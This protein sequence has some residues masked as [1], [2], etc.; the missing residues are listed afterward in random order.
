MPD[1]GHRWEVCV[2]VHSQ[3][4]QKAHCWY[5]VLACFFYVSMRILQAECFL[6]GFSKNI[7]FEC[8]HCIHLVTDVFLQSIDHQNMGQTQDC[9]LCSFVALFVQLEDPKTFFLCLGSS[10]ATHSLSSSVTAV[11]SSWVSSWRAPA[12]AVYWTLPKQTPCTVVQH[13]GTE[14]WTQERSV[15]ADLWRLDCL[16]P[17]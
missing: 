3:R 16:V 15:T 4:W 8:F 1:G 7:S 6:N 10:S 5:D 9:V 2:S 12:S 11:W 13:V 14:W 17:D